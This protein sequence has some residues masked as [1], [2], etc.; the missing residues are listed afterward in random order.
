MHG[1]TVAG[2]NYIRQAEAPRFWQRAL[3]WISAAEVRPDRYRTGAGAGPTPSATPLPAATDSP[4][5]WSP[6]DPAQ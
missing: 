4:A 6:F 2:G 3:D 1:L 5:V